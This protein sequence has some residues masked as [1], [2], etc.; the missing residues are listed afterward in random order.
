VSKCSVDGCDRKVLSRGYCNAHYIR[1]RTTGDVQA[2]TPLQITG[3]KAKA[4][5]EVR[6]WRNVA[7]RGA[8][9]CWI[10]GVGG[11]RR[12]RTF[13]LGAK[14]D[15]TIGAHKFSYELHNGQVPEGMVVMHSCDNP[16]CVNPAHLVL[17]T[18][19][20]NMQDMHAKGRAKPGRAI[21]ERNPNVRLTPEL[22]RLIRGSA[23]GNKELAAE[24][25]VG[26]NT[27]RGVRIGRTWK[28]VK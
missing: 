22:V 25:G 5:P 15:G 10:F 14:A 16:T 4:P 27:V 11:Y 28:H 7:K 9:D 26:I 12:Y 3:S 23:K 13:S 18:Y 8:G 20:A 1:W 19:L 24:L 2:H 6:F 21:G 17:G